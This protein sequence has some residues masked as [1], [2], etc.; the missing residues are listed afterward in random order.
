M[1]GSWQIF[2]V[3]LLMAGT[4][5]GVLLGLR[6]QRI[7]HG[8]SVADIRARL[9]A[10]T[11]VLQLPAP[12]VLLSGHGEPDHAYDSSEAH[13]VM[14]D[15]L[16]CAVTRCRCKAAAYQVLVDAGKLKPRRA[17]LSPSSHG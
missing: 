9:V 8:R 16:D 12:L 13:R 4:M 2:A 17:L 11:S 10:E 7:P 3:T 1:M 14:Q 15:H 6:P 5:A